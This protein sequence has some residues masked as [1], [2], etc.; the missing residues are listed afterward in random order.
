MH[1]VGYWSSK[2]KNKLMATVGR[3]TLH[4]EPIIERLEFHY[5]KQKE[6]SRYSIL[7]RTTKDIA[8]TYA[9]WSD[10]DW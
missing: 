4:R 8:S 9:S 6:I 7:M 5:D 10:R 2:C 3:E 1:I